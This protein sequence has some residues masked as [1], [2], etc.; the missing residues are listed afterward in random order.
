MLP[1]PGLVSSK[2]QLLVSGGGL[3]GCHTRG[4]DRTSD[5]SARADHGVGCSKE[6]AD[7]VA[8]LALGRQ[9]MGEGVGVAEGRGRQAVMC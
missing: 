7:V 6:Q 2:F 4:D 1:L 8:G 3:P 9:E 5:Y